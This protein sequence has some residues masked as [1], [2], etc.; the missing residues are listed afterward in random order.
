MNGGPAPFPPSGD[1]PADERLTAHWAVLGKYP[2]RTMGYEVLGGSLP[3][4]R[5]KNYL[6]GAAAVGAPDER[7]TWGG[8]PWRVF[9]SGVQ[10]EAAA[11]AVVET[12]WDGSRDG[13]GAA[14]YAWRL[15]LLDWT[16]ASAAGVTWST[17]DRAA[18][19]MQ[20]PALTE[21]AP[22]ATGPAVPMDVRRTAAAEQADTV[23]TLGF[24]WAAG[25]AALLLDGTPVALVP[26]SGADVPGTAERVRIL[27]AVCSLLPYG[28]R[29]WLSAATWTGRSDHELMLVFAPA[30]RGRQL[31]VGLDGGP[32]PQPQS[33]QAR[34]Y[35]AELF[36]LRERGRTTVDLVGHLLAKPA[37]ISFRDREEAVRVLKDLDLLDSVI[38][39]ITQGRGDVRDVRRVLE[40]HPVTT[41][42]EHRL[43]VLV[44][45]LARKAIRDELVGREAAEVLFGHWSP[46]TPRLIAQDVLAAPAS[47]KSFDEAAEY[48]ALLRGSGVRQPGA[49]EELF[50]DLVDAPGQDAEWV[51]GLIRKAERDFGHQSEA[52]YRVLVASRAVGLA[53]LSLLLKPRRPELSALSPVV[54]FA[55]HQGA[56]AMPGWLR[57]GALLTG[58]LTPEHV[59]ESDAAEFTARRSDAW[60]IALDTADPGCRPALIGL[61]WPDLLQAV[62]G[63]GRRDLLSL[64]DRIAPPGQPGLGP[65]IAAD[66][67]L[68]RA[69]GS[70]TGPLGVPPSMPRLCLLTGADRLGA[71]ASALQ[72]RIESD[73]GLGQVAVEALLGS[74]PDERCWAVLLQLGPG[75]LVRDGIARRLRGD[76]YA[77]WLGLELHEDMVEALSRYDDLRWLPHVLEMRRAVRSGGS[78]AQIVQIIYAACPDRRFS[79]QLAGEIFEWMARHAPA[80]GHELVDALDKRVT[81][82]GVALY[83]LVGRDKRAARLRERLLPVAQFEKDRAHRRLT[84]LE[85]I[86]QPGGRRPAV[87]SPPAADA[88]T[89]RYEGAGSHAGPGGYAGGGSPSRPGASGR[90]DGSGSPARNDGSGS[91][92]RYDGSGSSAGY[93]AG[94]GPS[95]GAGSGYG[96]HDGLARG[97]DGG[98]GAMSRTGSAS[99]PGSSAPPAREPYPRNP[100]PPSRAAA[101]AYDWAENGDFLHR[102]PAPPEQASNPQQLPPPEQP[103]ASQQLPPE[104]RP[105]THKKK[106]GRRWKLGR[107]EP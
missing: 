58:D 74:S 47:T 40:R 100:Q 17:L 44:V 65:G 45:F 105:E 89:R 1:D 59:T 56:D 9:L 81:D 57:F 97:T 37:A 7:D 8:L 10:G 68:L 76:H 26:R 42:D 67:D 20:W 24:A 4:D 29:V 83:D 63:P 55:L 80:V 53:W 39:E 2:G 73:P 71:Y 31:E 62:R 90:Y 87:S 13:T 12:A 33:H 84:A 95:G 51:A 46:L 52:A 50:L 99:P 93:R 32:P 102:A 36:R 6:W 54:R 64:L 92:A 22:A 11:C 21:G 82:L 98:S 23:D 49:F 15:L 27:D 60:R 14:S 88:S 34:A 91:S 94:S 16:S 38:E 61:L 104:E 79:R 96:L 106:Q 28:C 25:V 43:A 35:L 69:L 77:V 101:P 107:R 78:I 85:G 70:D 19:A 3:E 5:A 86:P 41:L 75:P 66:A 103:R 18:A 30:A 48:L 72:R